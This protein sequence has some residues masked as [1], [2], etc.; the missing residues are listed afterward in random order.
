MNPERAKA[1]E[2]GAKFYFGTKACNNGNF[3]PR[4]TSD[5]GCA[6]DVCKEQKLQYRNGRKDATRENNKR[7]HEANKER[8]NEKSRLNNPIY[9]RENKEKLSIK[10]KSWYSENKT[11]KL[12]KDKIYRETN[13]KRILEQR[14]VYRQENR[15]IV[16][17]GKLRRKAALKN[18]RVKWDN[19]ELT[20]LVELE[21]TDLCILREKITGFEWHV[22]HMIP[23]CA[24]SVSGLHVWNNLQC[25]PASINESKG[26]RLLLT[27][28]LEWMKKNV[29]I[30]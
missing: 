29:G 12:N 5:N 14:K 19:D 26:N 9:Q 13:R 21:A 1:I 8:M 16:R 11:E 3:G 18:A 22:D 15:D 25:L 6:C 17:A 20:L 28:E 24:E 2:D 10:R 7:F 4:Y 27:N 30:L 23:I